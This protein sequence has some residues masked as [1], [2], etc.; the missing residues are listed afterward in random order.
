MSLWGDSLHQYLS[1]FYMQTNSYIAF[2]VLDVELRITKNSQC[3]FHY[4]LSSQVSYI[5]CLSSSITYSFSL[6]TLPSFHVSSPLFLHSYTFYNF[7]ILWAA[8]F[9]YWICNTVFSVLCIHP[10]ADTLKSRI[11]CHLFLIFIPACSLF[12]LQIIKGDNEIATFSNSTNI[13]LCITMSPNSRTL[14]SLTSPS[15]KQWY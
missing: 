1:F 7:L 6:F 4:F 9:E 3:L 15:L 11:Y 8:Y 13:H 5:H 12:T 14:T 2:H 10:L